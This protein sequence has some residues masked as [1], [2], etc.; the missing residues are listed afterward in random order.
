[1]NFKFDNMPEF[2]TPIIKL[3]S[4]NISII[5]GT[6]IVDADQL[7][8]TIHTVTTPVVDILK[9]CAVLFGMYYTR[10]TYQNHEKKRNGSK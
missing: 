7:A 6:I 9:I 3:W 5:F 2:M 8:H 10:K 1:M 4:V